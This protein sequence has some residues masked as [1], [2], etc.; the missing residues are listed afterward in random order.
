[1][2]NILLLWQQESYPQ[3]AVKVTE[4]RGLFMQEAV[5]EGKGSWL[6]FLA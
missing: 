2:E 5:P 4:K 3:D 1:L 6:Q